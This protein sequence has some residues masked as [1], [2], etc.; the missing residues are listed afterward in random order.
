M[1]GHGQYSQWRTWGEADEK[2]NYS[3]LVHPDIFTVKWD[4]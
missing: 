3:L 1:N 2:D 4:E